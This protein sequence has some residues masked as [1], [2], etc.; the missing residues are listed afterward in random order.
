MKKANLFRQ[1]LQLL[2]LVALK[3]FVLTLRLLL[4]VLLH[5]ME[6]LFGLKMGPVQLLQEEQLLQEM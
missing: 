6:Q 4:V 5:Q 2:L 1:H 3:L